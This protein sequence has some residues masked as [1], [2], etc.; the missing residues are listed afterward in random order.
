MTKV[1]SSKTNRNWVI[2][3]FEG[4]DGVYLNGG[5]YW[6]T[7]QLMQDAT[8]FGVE[9]NARGQFHYM[10]NADSFMQGAE[11]PTDPF[12]PHGS[13]T[14]TVQGGFAMFA[15]YSNTGVKTHR[16]TK[17][18][19]NDLHNWGN[20]DSSACE[21]CLDT[22]DITDGTECIMTK[23]Q[24]CQSMKFIEAEG[25]KMD[26]ACQLTWGLK[27]YNTLDNMECHGEPI[28]GPGG[29]TETM[30]NTAEDC[31]QLCYKANAQYH[32]YN[33]GTFAA[34]PGNAQYCE[35]FEY[36]PNSRICRM[37]TSIAPASTV[38]VTCYVSKEL[39]DPC[40]LKPGIWLQDLERN[41][42][43]TADT[44][45]SL[46]QAKDELTCF[47][48]PI[49]AGED[50]PHFSCDATVDPNCETCITTAVSH[51]KLLGDMTCDNL[52]AKRKRV[53]QYDE[54]DI[55]CAKGE[56][57]RVLEASY[58]RFDEG[59]CSNPSVPPTNIDTMCGDPNNVQVYMK[60]TC[61]G[62]QMC[63]IMAD[64]QSLGDQGCGHV[65]KYAEVRYQCV[66]A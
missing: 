37:L 46:V 62:K 7:F 55:E 31:A 26:L 32:E 33:L 39:G 9:G 42:Y 17:E 41:I 64:D 59:P 47:G 54:A 3:G 2:L 50:A 51:N 12:D 30:R 61:N 5:F 15:T 25:L 36:N 60:T 14:E 4:D 16:E 13:T 10:T 52:Y 6:L 40:H 35:A 43:Y 28:I 63:T 1:G 23:D 8:C 56:T 19:C 57:I 22:I 44:T 11:S 21:Q 58:G 66:A 27:M 38:G 20:L 24:G 49:W 65:Y 29:Q 48:E 18:A 53:C 34:E 45:G